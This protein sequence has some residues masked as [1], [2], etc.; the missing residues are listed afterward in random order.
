[1]EQLLLSLLLVTANVFGVAMIIPQVVRLH[2]SRSADGVSLAWIGVSIAMN[3]WWTAYAIDAE[4]W[5]LLPVSVGG[6]SMYLIMTGQ[7]IGL[8]GAGAFGPLLFGLLILGMIPLP[9]FFIGGM[10]AAG[11]AAGLCYGG[12]F[13]PAVVTALRSATLHGLSP[14]TWFMAWVEAVVWIIY[15]A[16]S[17]DEALLVGGVGGTVASTVILA[18]LVTSRRPGLAIR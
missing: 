17:S 5:G 6:A 18:R 7:M 10:A 1:M 2:T 16:T 8:R 9:F 3:G 13:L 12:Q 15:G 4:L 14:A 11:L